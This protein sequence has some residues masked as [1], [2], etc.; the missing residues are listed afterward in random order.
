MRDEAL[1]LGLDG[2]RAGSV[3]STLINLSLTIKGVYVHARAMLAS[4]TAFISYS[5]DSLE[6]VEQVAQLATRLR[7]DGI[8]V[9]LDQWIDSPPEGWPQWMERQISQAQFVL[10]ICTSKYNA[11]SQ[12]KEQSGRG[13][14][15]R[16]ESLLSYQHIYDSNSENR[17]FIPV[18]FS[19]GDEVQIPMTLRGATYY[20]LSKENGYEQLYRR[21]TSQPSRLKPSLGPIKP[22]LPHA[23]GTASSPSITPAAASAADASGR[24]APS[25]YTRPSLREFIMNVL[26]TDSDLDAF[27]LDYFPT[28]KHVYSSGM[29]RVAKV[30]ILIEREDPEEVLQFLKEAIPTR[31]NRFQNLLRRARSDIR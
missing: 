6:H 30:N 11:R 13:L 20:N 23:D 10:I 12:G 16:W 2:R 5:H 9:E 27:A 4:V 1:R 21:L 28:T 15:A 26:I 29:D 17:R 18:V 25:Q 8:D 22:M 14:G 19:S 7:L 31:F 3:A 24:A